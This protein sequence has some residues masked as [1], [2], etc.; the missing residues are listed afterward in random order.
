MKAYLL[1]IVFLP[2]F[3]SLRN[4]AALSEA[5]EAWQAEALRLVNQARIRGCR[6]GGKRMSPAPVLRFSEH[7]SRIAKGHADYLLRRGYITHRGPGGTRVGQ[8]A[9]RAGYRWRVIGEN[10]ASGYNTPRAVVQTWL[11]SPG[12]C[13]NIMDSQYSEMGIARAGNIYVQVLAKP[14]R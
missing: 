1:T 10:I 8:R 2:F 7:L 3:S 5:P 4:E 11:N 13:E 9:S 14:M 6:C 12:H